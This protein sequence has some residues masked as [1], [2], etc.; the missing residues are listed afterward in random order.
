[1][2]LFFRRLLIAVVYTLTLYRFLCFICNM[3]NLHLIKP[4]GKQT[5]YEAT[6]GMERAVLVFAVTAAILAA[7]F[8]LVPGK[9]TGSAM[10]HWLI[11]AGIYTLGVGVKLV[12]ENL[13]YKS[14]FSIHYISFAPHMLVLLLLLGLKLYLFRRWY[15]KTV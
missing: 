13:Y 9:M 7:F 6:I 11:D 4:L 3:A 1:M 5:Y 15:F 8:L 14:D 12:A 2:T 10:Q